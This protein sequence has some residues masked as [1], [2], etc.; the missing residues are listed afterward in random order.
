ML[1]SRLLA[2]ATMG[3]FAAI[4]GGMANPVPVPRAIVSSKAKRGLFNGWAYGSQILIGTK[5]AGVSMAQQ[6]RAAAKVRNRA[7]NK[8]K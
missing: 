8:R 6:K 2:L 1:K 3:A 5:G 4:P 7:R